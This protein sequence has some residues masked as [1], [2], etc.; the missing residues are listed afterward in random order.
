M[1]DFAKEFY[2]SKKWKACRASYIAKRMQVDGGV[3]EVCG[4][5]QGYIVHH[6]VLLTKENISNPMISLNHAYLRYEC[7]GC[8]DREE[9]H[10]LDAKGV[11][12]LTCIFG[13]DG[14]PKIDLRGIG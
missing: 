12:R 10:Y 2:Q 14:Q 11:K 8:H 3:C 9:G 5:E 1:K 7:K 4:Q 6:I 13:E